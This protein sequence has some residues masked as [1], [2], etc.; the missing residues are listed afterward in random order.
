[1][2]PLAPELREQLERVHGNWYPKVELL[3]ASAEHVRDYKEGMQ[4]GAV[5]PAGALAFSDDGSVR[6]AAVDAQQISQPSG[7]ALFTGLADDVAT[8]VQRLLLFELSTSVTPPARL[9]RARLRLHRKPSGAQP[10]F[11]GTFVL[12]AYVVGRTAASGQWTELVPYGSPI[13][14]RVDQV[15]WSLDEADV[16][17]VFPDGG[18]ELRLPLNPVTGRPADRYHIALALTIAGGTNTNA[19]WLHDTAITSGEFTDASGN[20]LTW[21]D[22]RAAG[23]DNELGGPGPQKISTGGPYNLIQSN[24]LGRVTLFVRNNSVTSA[25]LT[26]SGSSQF[27]LG[28]PPSGDQELVAL[29]ETP[30]G[31]SLKF[32]VWNG[33]TWV[34]F[35][36]GDKVGED[37]TPSGGK[38]LISVPKGQ[39]KDIRVTFTGSAD[40][41]R[42]PVLRAVGMRDIKV[43]DVSRL[44][45]QLPDTFYQVSDIVSCR[46]EV[47]E[48][49]L[50]LIKHGHRG[51]ALDAITELLAQTVNISAAHVRI[52]ISAPGIPRRADLHV[53]TYRVDDYEP[54]DAGVDLI[55]VSV[56]DRLRL[57]IPK[58]KLVGTDWIVEPAVYASV[59]GDHIRDVFTDLRD[60]QLGLAARYRG[61]VPQGGPIGPDGVQ[62]S[63]IQGQVGAPGIGTS[64]KTE[65]A[66]DV[67]EQLARIAGGVL[68]TSRGKIHYR[69]LFGPKHV[70][71]IFPEREIEWLQTSPGLRQRAPRALIP[72]QPATLG[73]TDWTKS[74]QREDATILAAIE[75]AGTEAGITVDEIPPEVSRWVRTSSPASGSG[76]DDAVALADALVHRHVRLFGAGLLVWRFRSRIPHPWLEIGDMVAVE[77]TRFAGR[78]P[79]S[80]RAIY[81]PIWAR[82][83]ITGRNLLGT[84]FAVWVRS[85]TDISPSQLFVTQRGTSEPIVT[86]TV[87]DVDGRPDQARVRIQSTPSGTDVTIRY[88]VINATAAL[89]AQSLDGA[90]WSTYAGPVLITRDASA[91]QRVVAWADWAGAWGPREV[92]EI[93]PDRRPQVLGIAIRVTPDGNVTATIQSDAD[94]GSVKFVGRKTGFPSLADVQARPAN[95]GRNVTGAVIDAATGLAMRLLPGEVAYVAAVAYSRAGGTGVEGPMALATSAATEYTPSVKAEPSQ[96]ATGTGRIDL[97]IWDPALR[98]TAVEYQTKTGTGDYGGTWLSAWDASTGTAGTDQVLTRRK[99]VALQSGHQSAIKWRVL[100]LDQQDQTREIA[101]S[102]TFDAD[103]IAD[104]GAPEISFESSGEVVVS[105]AGDEDT[106]KIYVT[107]AASND[108]N[109]IPPDPTTSSPA[110]INARQGTVATGVPCGE[111]QV[112]VVKVRGW[113]GTSGLGPVVSAKLRRPVT[114]DTG[115]RWTSQVDGWSTTQ[116]AAAPENGAQITVPAGGGSLYSNLEDANDNTTTYY[117]RYDVYLSAMTEAIGAQVRLY[118]NDAPGSTNW[119]QVASKSYAAFQDFIAEQLSFEAA[120]GQNYD[121][122]LEMVYDSTPTNPLGVLKGYGEA[123]NPPGVSYS[124]LDAPIPVG[125]GGTGQTSLTNAALLVGAGTAPISTL[126]PSATPGYVVRSTGTAWAAAQLGFGDLS[127]SAARGQLPPAIAYEDEINIFTAKQRLEAALEF[128]DLDATPVADRRL[129]VVDGLLRATDT[130]DAEGR[131]IS[132]LSLEQI[133]NAELAANA[134]IAVSKLAAGGANSVLWSDGVTAQWTNLPAVAQLRYPNTFEVFYDGSADHGIEHFFDLGFGD[135]IRFKSPVSAQYWDGTAWVAWSQS[136]AELTDGLQSTAV[137]VD[138]THRQFRL[139][140]DPGVSF[141]HIQYVV[142]NREFSTGLP[143]YDLTIETSPDQVAWTNRGSW[144]GISGQYRQVFVLSSDIG[145]HRYIRFTFTCNLA[146]GQTL[147]FR[148][149][150]VRSQRADFSSLFPFSWDSQRNLTVRGDGTAA[151][152]AWSFA[153]D[154]NT[155]IFRPAADVLGFA[156]AGSERMR[157]NAAGATIIGADPG[158]SALLRVGGNAVFNGNVGVG[159]VSPT[160][161]LEL[162]NIGVQPAIKWTATG[163]RTYGIEPY[164]NRLILADLGV[165]RIF[166][167]DPSGWL[168]LQAP[169][170]NIYLSSAGVA[171]G[172]T[173]PQSYKLRVAGTSKIDN[174][175][176]VGSLG[177]FDSTDVPTEGQ[178]LIYKAGSIN[179]W[180]AETLNAVWGDSDFKAQILTEGAA[181]YVFRDPGTTTHSLGAPDAPSTPKVYQSHA[182]NTLE[183]ENYTKDPTKFRYFEWEIQKSTDG[184]TT[185]GAA[186]TV[187]TTS[188]KLVHA[189][190]DLSST[191]VRYR[192]RVRAINRDAAQGHSAFS[193]YTAAIQPKTDSSTHAFGGIIA[194]EIAVANL[195]AISADIGIITAGQLRNT[196]NTAGVNLGGAGGIPGSWTM[197]INFES[198]AT[199]SGMTRYLDFAAGAGAAWLKAEKFELK[200]DGTAIFRG[201]A[202]DADA[203]P[204]LKIDFPNKLLTV[205]DEQATPRVRVELGKFGTGSAYGLKLY[206][207][208]G[209]LDFDTTTGFIDCLEDFY[210]EKAIFVGNAPPWP[211]SRIGTIIRSDRLE[212]D[213]ITGSPALERGYMFQLASVGAADKKLVL[214]P[215]TAGNN[216]EDLF[217][218]DTALKIQTITNA[219]TWQQTTTATNDT[220]AL[221]SF[222][223][224]TSG[225]MLDGFGLELLFRAEDTGGIF[226]LGSLKWSRQGADN[227]GRFAIITNNAGSWGDRLYVHPSGDL[228]L[229]YGLRGSYLRTTRSTTGNFSLDGTTMFH[230]VFNTSGGTINLIGLTNGAKGKVCF[231]VS[232]DGGLQVMHESTAAAAQ[233]RITVLF[234]GNTLGRG[235]TGIF[236]YDDTDSRWIFV[237]KTRAN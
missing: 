60:G 143:T 1:M 28:A 32:E 120:L 225:D 173:D 125:T 58:R 52:S 170:I 215:I 79:R 135:L 220:N 91:V 117:V 213:A 19:A 145:S 203:N 65:L 69:D 172:S 85:Y 42:T 189:R 156:T 152:P 207:T 12:H 49:R 155:G 70:T 78:D 102:H 93:A 129:R 50:S 118:H 141:R 153:N 106:Q 138:Y 74:I 123:D 227:K 4:E 127:G 11:D 126:A 136:F 25:T 101:G 216:A 16:D 174:D 17:F 45:A 133:T 149:I 43:T 15:T 75:Q 31:T 51:D 24:S 10:A 150:H 237:G 209:L 55:C 30:T 103:T 166:E 87:E 231:V 198:G 40:G 175:L 160:A 111:G 196:G 147:S 7:T 206:G 39:T 36:D 110:V 204:K 144:T 184:G 168:N 92:A 199:V 232:N 68:T 97:T 121:L 235:E 180:Q 162:A 200:T 233:D 236:V 83:V 139:V 165:T 163:G 72:F 2:I 185:W 190:L 187:N 73:G 104:V 59:P 219:I 154:S 23:L 71:A 131:Y 9:T 107:V 192:Y 161:K 197:G 159:A 53:D 157:I 38:N 181:A 96:P 208:D 158:G 191:N 81:G 202:Q 178:I 84:E 130:V 105:A 124:R 57:P 234:A 35:V 44:V 66:K 224:K 86:I 21:Y 223:R 8:T 171:V 151:A 183:I 94:T 186:I 61:S 122:R 195:A 188:V 100:Y 114:G 148:Q 230:R 164:D 212:F 82:A 109:T 142:V 116:N 115:A 76:S 169:G 27:D 6:L 167:Y 29:G 218:L 119:T 193:P 33:A 108:G 179:K 177:V 217:E 214:K 62:R 137:D 90:V 134:A 47:A 229:L 34:E 67:L 201:V 210:A 98:V 221:I 77:T 99:D 18:A 63:L 112:A 222:V 56:L 22:V 64:G 128:K 41:L 211:G 95:D 13:E 80:G 228:E 226:S 20:R 89:P 176:T 205:T 194:G 146:V 132:R 3:T 54:H 48:L 182:T 140:Y 113:N 46:S 37:N 26:F 5:S 88:A 14:V